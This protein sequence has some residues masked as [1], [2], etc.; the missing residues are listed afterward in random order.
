ME[1]D[2]LS[3]EYGHFLP[4]H[5]KCYAVHGHSSRVRV[6]ISG[7][8]EGGMLVDF[9]AAKDAV[10]RV[11]EGFDHRLIASGK[12]AEQVG[13][14][15]LVRYEAGGGRFEL[16]LPASRVVLLPGEA[17]VENIATAVAAAVM[18]TMPSNVTS[19]TLSLSEGFRKGA[20][21]TLSGRGGAG[22]GAGGR[23]RAL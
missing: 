12:Y 7:E 6:E 13:E 14:E 22:A 17:T 16:R 11:L 18:G 9:G 20:E 4:W 21:V 15:V 2:D 23:L 5:R 19:I 3:F 1:G 8:L 10:K